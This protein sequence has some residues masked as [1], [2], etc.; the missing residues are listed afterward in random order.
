[1]TSPPSLTTPAT[2]TSPVGTYAINVSG[3]SSPDY[4][5]TY[6]PGTLTVA[7]AGTSAALSETAGT[8]VIG[9]PVTFTVQ[10][11]PISPS[12][13]HPTGTVS[14]F[15]D[16]NSLGTAAV[17]PA[18]GQ[19]SISTASLG[20]GSHAITA[21]YSGDSNYTASQTASSQSTS[22]TQI[23]V[24]PASTATVLSTVAVRNKHGKIVKV[25]LESRVTVVSPGVGTSTG[26]V[27]YYRGG[28]A[29]ATMGLSDGAAVLTLKSA[30]ALKKKFSV[31]YDGNANF[32]P[33]A[34]ATVAVTK[35]TL[36][37]VD[38]PATAFLKHRKG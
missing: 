23:T 12:T 2:A 30:K 32:N 1:M 8:S 19:A 31:R 7:K 35:K 4:T 3:A 22:T 20:S 21:D 5:I 33:S 14:F 24:S 27:T 18:T 9:Q 26:D 36:A 6:V 13:G 17:D 10:V 38:R 25:M 29:F 34:S 28:R 37:L 16:G 15:A 11:A